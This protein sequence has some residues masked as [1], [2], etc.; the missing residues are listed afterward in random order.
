MSSARARGLPGRGPVA[1]WRT[2]GVQTQREN[3]R[4]HRT[5]IFL[6]ATLNQVPREDAPTDDDFCD[7]ISVE[8]GDS[9]QKI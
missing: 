2:M 5:T 4:T 3:D 8:L 9:E 7:H 1:R 6:N